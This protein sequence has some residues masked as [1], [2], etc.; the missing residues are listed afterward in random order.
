MIY[1]CRGPG[2]LAVVDSTP[3]TTL[4]LLSRQSSCVSPVELI[5]G[6]EG[7]GLG[8]EP[9]HSKARKPGPLYIIQYSLL[10]VYCTVLYIS[11]ACT[12]HQDSSKSMYSGVHTNIMLLV[13]LCYGNSL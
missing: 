6:R 7:E 9:N 10:H 8:K 2:F 12:A 11:K 3:R 5:D 1:T 4:F 13:V